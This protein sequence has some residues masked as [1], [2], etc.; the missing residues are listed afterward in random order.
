MK[1]EVQK[2]QPNEQIIDSLYKNIEKIIIKNKS[3]MM[4]QINN[5]LVNT[6]FMIGKIIVENEQKGNFRAEYGKE[7]LN[8]LSKRLVHSFGTGFSR[9]NLK[10][11]RLFY[12]KYKKSQP[13]VG[14]LSWSHYCYL[15]YIENDAERSFYEK[16][17]IN[18]KWSKRE[19]KRQIDFALFQRLLLSGGTLN[20]TK[21]YELS[22][23]GQTING[24]A[25]ILKEP[26][27]FEFLG[28]QEEKPVLES[29]LEKALVNHLSKFILELGK[30][31]CM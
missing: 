25:D 23:N 3:K 11:M 2:I 17:C 8:D 6:Y 12:I 18:Q 19:L 31:L 24:P 10:N 7:V 4:Y 13:L 30:G 9:T 21:V 26:Y 29:D 1:T 28:I 14:Q 5:A 16:E 27:V 22:K 15:I 20:E